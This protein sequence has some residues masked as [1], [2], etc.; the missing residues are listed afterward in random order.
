MNK[1]IIFLIII[2]IS[3]L[4]TIIFMIIDY[5]YN[6]R[7]KY[8]SFV[9]K[10][11]LIFYI[12]LIIWIITLVSIISICNNYYICLILILY[13]N[14]FMNLYHGVKNWKFAYNVYVKNIDL[15][16]KAIEKDNNN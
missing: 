14:L 11:K 5:R 15:L 1:L 10:S 16:L 12:V 9:A 2:T 6:V 7:I 3:F 8:F 4:S 13:F